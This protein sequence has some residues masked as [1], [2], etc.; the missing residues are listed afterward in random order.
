M[1]IA[2]IIKELE[3]VSS[4]DLR[5]AVKGIRDVYRVFPAELQKQMLGEYSDTEYALMSALRKQGQT[6]SGTLSS[7]DIETVFDIYKVNKS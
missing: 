3:S 7:T 1:I 2:D 5:R 6:L 4:G